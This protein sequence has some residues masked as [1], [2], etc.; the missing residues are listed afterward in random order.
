MDH[1]NNVCEDSPS[2]CVRVSVEII[3][4]KQEWK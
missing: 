1:K 2:D 4:Q 3:K